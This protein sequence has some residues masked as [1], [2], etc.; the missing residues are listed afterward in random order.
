MVSPPASK[1]ARSSGDKVEVLMPRLS[2]SFSS[3]ASFSSLRQEYPVV[4][5]IHSK[6]REGRIRLGLTEEAF[7]EKVGVSRGAVQQW[8]KEDGTAPNR[9]RQEAVAKLLGISVAELLTDQPLPDWPFMQITPE[10]VQ[11]LSADKLEKLENYA[12]GLLGFVPKLVSVPS[13]IDNPL[14]GPPPTR[15]EVTWTDPNKR[16]KNN[17]SSTRTKAAGGKHGGSRSA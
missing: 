17:G 4:M 9:G 12:L 14:V 11:T 16:K 5:S 10:Q 15:R 8:E 1:I 7:G 2:A 6:I 3:N 13:Y